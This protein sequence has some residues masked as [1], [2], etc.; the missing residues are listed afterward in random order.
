MPRT[1]AGHI[2]KARSQQRSGLPGSH[3][4]PAYAQHQSEHPGAFRTQPQEATHGT[5]E[6][7]DVAL[8]LAST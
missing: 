5:C 1:G 3:G 7:R 2:A 6:I 4:N 8:H